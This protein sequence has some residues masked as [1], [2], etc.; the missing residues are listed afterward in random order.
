MGEDFDVP[1]SFTMPLPPKS[2]HEGRVTR[3]LETPCLLIRLVLDRRQA[4]RKEPRGLGRTIKGKLTAGSRNPLGLAGPEVFSA[5]HKSWGCC[6]PQ[7]LALPF[8]PGGW[9]EGEEVDHS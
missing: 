9:E 1:A 8:F 6:S 3:G 5:S 2:Q 4:G 7:A